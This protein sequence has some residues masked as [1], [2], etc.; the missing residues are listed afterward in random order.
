MKNNSP[1]SPTGEIG[2]PLSN[3]WMRTSPVISLGPTLALGR[4]LLVTWFYS[5]HPTALMRAHVGL[6]VLMSRFLT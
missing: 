5:S 6:G 2:T 1:R 4:S 3:V